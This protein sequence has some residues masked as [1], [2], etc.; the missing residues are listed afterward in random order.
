M[1]RIGEMEPYSLISDSFKGEKDVH[2]IYNLYSVILV[3]VAKDNGMRL[4][5]TIDV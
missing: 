3:T 5:K 1:C 2:S 4:F